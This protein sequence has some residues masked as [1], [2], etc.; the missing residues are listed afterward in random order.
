MKPLKIRNHAYT[1]AYATVIYDYLA[2]PMYAHLYDSPS[3][4]QYIVMQ[5]IDQSQYI[6]QRIMSS[7]MIMDK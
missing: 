2:K 5:C 7:I 4:C 6:A 1:N 3:G